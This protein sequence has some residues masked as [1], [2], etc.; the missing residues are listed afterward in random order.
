MDEIILGSPNS[1]LQVGNSVRAPRAR[2]SHI[3]VVRV[4]SG[5]FRYFDSRWKN[6]RRSLES[7]KILHMPLDSTGV[8]RHLSLALGTTR[9]VKWR[10]GFRHMVMHPAA[11]GRARSAGRLG[12]LTWFLDSKGI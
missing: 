12:A 1:F 7:G 11:F 2:S 9:S 3:Y 10:L 8:T 5:F 4:D 6:S